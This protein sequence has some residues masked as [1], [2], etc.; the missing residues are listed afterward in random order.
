MYG[1]EMFFNNKNNHK[2]IM[3]KTI[4]EIGLK[5]ISQLEILHKLGYVHND[6]KL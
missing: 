1:I 5:I 2:Q 4:S 6:L 3:L